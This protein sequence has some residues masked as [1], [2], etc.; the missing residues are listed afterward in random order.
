MFLV[1]ASRAQIAVSPEEAEIERKVNEAFRSKSKTDYR[2]ADDIKPY[3]K[4]IM[5]FLVR[6]LS[7]PDGSVQLQVLEL[8]K[9]IKEMESVPL[10]LTALNS[11][12]S[13]V[14]RT[15]AEY[16]FDNFAAS[17]LAER[18]DLKNALIKNISSKNRNLNV[19]TL[20]GY[21]SGDDTEK[22]LLSVE[23][24]ETFGFRSVKD[25]C[26]GTTVK[27]NAPLSL[28]LYR[29]NRAKHYERLKT[30]IARADSADSE[31]FL[32]SIKYID[33]KNL[34]KAL[35]E[36]GIKNPAILESAYGIE[37]QL[38]SSPERIKDLTVFQFVKKLNLKDLMISEDEPGRYSSKLTQNAVGKIREKLN[39]M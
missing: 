21:L 29:I 12:N 25:G 6:Y 31:F 30:A 13:A 9:D 20:L 18:G 35:F 22:A 7:D 4:K 39:S 14:S 33:D 15:S 17:A 19:V 11:T 38:P 2:W 37:G 36:K 34:L 23:T 32:C 24:D 1:G 26:F 8:L 10:L 28:S 5:P 16:L 3:G 27:L